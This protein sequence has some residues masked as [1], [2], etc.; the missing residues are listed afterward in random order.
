MCVYAPMCVYAQ[1]QAMVC[2]WKSQNFL[3]S[4]LFGFQRLNLGWQACTASTFISRAVLPA[5][6][7]IFYAVI[8]ITVV[9]VNKNLL[10]FCISFWSVK[11]KKTENYF[12]TSFFLFSS[13]LT[14]LRTSYVAQNQPGVHY[15]SPPS[16]FWRLRFQRLAT[17]SRKHFKNAVMFSVTV[18]PSM[19]LT[20]GYNFNFQS[21]TMFHFETTGAVLQPDWW[22]PWTHKLLEWQASF[23]QVHKVEWTESVVT[24]S[25]C[26]R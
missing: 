26:G 5:L 7:F 4:T 6:T 1:A 16:A 9:H 20:T 22:S 12:L 11:E 18:F 2:M 17:N 3:H 10:G 15:S 19:T 23:A 8:L 21:V 24:F 13:P 14:L 25:N